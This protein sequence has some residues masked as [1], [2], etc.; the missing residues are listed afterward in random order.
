MN[1]QQKIHPIEEVMKD[2][3]H[4]TSA[5]PAVTE[6]TEFRNL[7]I[8][9]SVT[10]YPE[11]SRLALE[12]ISGFSLT[13]YTHGLGVNPDSNNPRIP[14]MVW[15]STA[16]TIKVLEET[17]RNAKKAL[18]SSL[19]SRLLDSLVALV[20][21]AAY[22]P[23]CLDPSEDL[24]I[25]RVTFFAHVVQ[26]LLQINENDFEVEME[27]D[28]ESTRPFSSIFD[29][30]LNDENSSDGEF[31][32]AILNGGRHYLGLPAVN[33]NSSKLL[34]Y[35]KEQCLPFLRC[36]G[37]FF[38]LLTEVSVPEELKSNV[39]VP[40]SEYFCL[41]R[42]L[43]LEPHFFINFNVRCFD[44]LLKTW[45]KHP[46]MPDAMS[47]MKNVNLFTHINCL[48]PLPKDYSELMNTVSQFP[49]HASIGD[50]SR[51]P[52][53]CLT[54]GKMLC[55]Q[56]VRRKSTLSSFGLFGLALI[57]LISPA[58]LQKKIEYFMRLC[59]FVTPPYLDEYGE[60]DHGL[61]RGNPLRLDETSYSR[62]HNMWLSHSVPDV[63]AHTTE[64]TSNVMLTEW[65]HY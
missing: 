39:W 29:Y 8:C 24:Y 15:A 3:S 43:G 57:K 31:L 22:I 18:L 20:N 25:L 16:Y 58:C 54:C 19:S 27:C 53:M 7:F 5:S 4:L 34:D 13:I 56:R 32:L 38:H 64:G 33:A 44:D 21:F 65:F 49:C 60:A 2:L 11:F 35:V 51:T 10:P 6:S 37:L 42:Y 9:D 55:S 1:A 17:Q 28:S 26:I 14:Q 59:C 46:K 63:I 47:Q 41:L 52:T 12:M 48:I 23:V 61:K 45:C 30:A 40:E 62:L 36:C 50:D